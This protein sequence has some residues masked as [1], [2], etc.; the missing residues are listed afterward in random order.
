MLYPWVLWFETS[1]GGAGSGEVGSR[2]RDGQDFKVVFLG[3]PAHSIEN[4]STSMHWIN[5]GI[6]FLFIWA[7]GLRC[8]FSFLL[9]IYLKNRSYIQWDISFFFIWVL[10]SLVRIE[11]TVGTDWPCP[12]LASEVF[13]SHI[14]DNRIL[15]NSIFGFFPSRIHWR[16]SQKKKKES[17]FILVHSFLFQPIFL[18]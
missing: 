15:D 14:W 16:S 13:F 18:N 3:H 7:W 4:W 10:A 9:N 8:F 12:A 11:E 2:P 6:Y 5:W 17:S 1:S